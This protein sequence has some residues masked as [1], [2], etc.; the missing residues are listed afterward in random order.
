MTAT[1]AFLFRAESYFEM[2]A[3]NNLNLGSPATPSVRVLG[4]TGVPIEDTDVSSDLLIVANDDI[5]LNASAVNGIS[6]QAPPQGII[7]FRD[8]LMIPSANLPNNACN[9]DRN[10]VFDL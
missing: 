7:D 6:I 1:G 5:T 2:V 3:G 10:L 9:G 8:G 4:G